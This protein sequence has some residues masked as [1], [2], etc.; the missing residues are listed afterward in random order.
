MEKK[1]SIE[2]CPRYIHAR[3]LCRHHYVQWYYG[4]IKCAAPLN[5]RVKGTGGYS[6]GGNG[7]FVLNGKKESRRIAEKA[8]GKPL[9]KGAEVHHVD[10][11]SENDKPTNLVICP[12]H[13]YHMLLH[14]RM[15]SLK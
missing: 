6:A 12:S 7:Y 8:L 14:A 15:R 9:P 2:G 10:G 1:C 11:N 13:A 4:R 3:N 5:R